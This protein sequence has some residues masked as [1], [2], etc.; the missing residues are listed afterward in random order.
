M[1]FRTAI[2]ILASLAGTSCTEATPPRTS[3]DAADRNIVIAGYST[4][5]V[6]DSYDSE[7]Q[8]PIDGCRFFTPAAD[9]ALIARVSTVS[10][11]LE[12][13]ACSASSTFI[14]PYWEVELEVFDTIYGATTDP[15]TAI[16]VAGF[17][18]GL[19]E[20]DDVV[21]VELI[22]LKGQLIADSSVFVESALATTS[23]RPGVAVDLP[24]T[25]PALRAE[26]AEVRSDF[27]KNCGHLGW[28][29]HSKNQYESTL[30]HD[31]SDRCQIIEEAVEDV[32]NV[33]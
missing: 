12:P 4:R 1:N 29:T 20:V 26:A 30:Y 28:A 19:P 14:A 15:V 31:G 11:L 2:V 18:N 27:Q 7:T 25:I 8:P 13:D 3:S 6:S 17:T 32:K 5:S 24:T 16:F 22:S 23:R 10:D 21:L 9:A 33:D